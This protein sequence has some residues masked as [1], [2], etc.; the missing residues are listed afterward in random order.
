MLFY[1]S[2]LLFITK[3]CSLL[4][5]FCSNI[6]EV[7]IIVLVLRI[8]VKLWSILLSICCVISFV[9]FYICIRTTSIL[10]VIGDDCWLGFCTGMYVESLLV[11]FSNTYF[12]FIKETCYYF[13]LCRWKCMYL[14][15]LFIVY[16]LTLFCAVNNELVGDML[17]PLITL[18]EDIVWLMALLFELVTFSENYSLSNWCSLNC[19]SDLSLCIIFLF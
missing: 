10:F 18:R 3:S 8:C 5:L 13:A 15:C 1:F 16:Y 6:Y 12:D 14:P 7:G 2:L 9:V 19:F 17:L 4:L 11:N